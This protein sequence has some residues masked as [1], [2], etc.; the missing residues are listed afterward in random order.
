[1]T[2]DNRSKFAT[3][4]G[5][6]LSEKL[7]RR[8]LTQSDLA[9]SVGTSPSY[10]SHTMKGRK[11]VSPAWVEMVADVLSL[12]TRERTELHHA[13]AIDTGFKL[14]PLPPA[15]APPSAPPS[16]R[17]AAAPAPA[18][19]PKKSRKARNSWFRS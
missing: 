19:A 17:T 11:S 2:E 16:A 1:V 6:A 15:P 13:A 8:S 7:E 3:A 9:K 4:F 5:A 18:Q 10:V 12:N 14:E